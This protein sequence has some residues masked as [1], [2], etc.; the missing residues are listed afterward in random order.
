MEGLNSSYKRYC[1]WGFKE[2]II[3]NVI[4]QLWEKMPLY[5]QLHQILKKLATVLAM[6]VPATHG[7][8]KNIIF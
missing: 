6:L 3:K 8:N 1:H 5:K 2:K 7:S 4:F